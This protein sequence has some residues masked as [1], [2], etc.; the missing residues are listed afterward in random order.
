MFEYREI[1]VVPA[2]QAGRPG[3][4]CG[5]KPGTQAAEKSDAGVVPKK[6]PN[7]IGW[8]ADGGSTGGKAGDQGEF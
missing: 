5:R 4:V 7:N 3:K 6:E 2:G 1:S 8:E